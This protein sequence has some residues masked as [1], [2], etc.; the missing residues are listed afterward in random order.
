MVNHRRYCIQQFIMIKD[1]DGD[2]LELGVGCGKNSVNLAMVIKGLG[3]DKKVYA[4]DTYSGLP[5]TDERSGIESDL[6]RGE[7]GEFTYQQLR[8]EALHKGISNI[9]ICVVGLVEE[10]LKKD[11]AD[12]RFCFVWFDLD[13]YKPTLYSYKFL[14]NRITKGGIIGFHDYEFIR[15]PGIKKVV[16]EVVDKKK[17]KKIYRKGTSIFFK[18]V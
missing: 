2:V 13:L 9:L 1:V 16:D 5:Y 8:S 4:C 17:Y 6:K 12:K 18:R 15:C 10:T 11:L 7:F 14:E 3:L